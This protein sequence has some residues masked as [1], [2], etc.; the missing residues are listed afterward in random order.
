MYICARLSVVPCHLN[1]PWQPKKKKD[2]LVWRISGNWRVSDCCFDLLAFS[3]KPEILPRNKMCHILDVFFSCAL[4][5]SCWTL[6]LSE[7]HCFSHSITIPAGISTHYIITCTYC[8]TGGGQQGLESLL[9]HSITPMTVPSTLVLY[10][11]WVD[12]TLIFRGW[13]NLLVFLTNQDWFHLCR[14]DKMVHSFHILIF[15]ILIMIRMGTHGV[16]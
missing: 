12:S 2:F 4:L 7:A 14:Q 16:T 1:A 8:T 6:T 10:S 3:G 15:I 13:Y 9:T 11:L 5:Y